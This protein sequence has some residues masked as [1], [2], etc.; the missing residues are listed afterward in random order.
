M[1]ASPWIIEPTAENFEAEVLVRSA[2][3]PVVVDFW[4]TWCAPC[5]QLA[6]ILEKLAQQYQ[7]QFI[8]AKVDTEKQP[9]LAAAFGVQSIPLV[10]AV[11]QG[12]IVDGFQGALG[13][14]Q[15]REFLDRILPSPM[16]K[17]LIEAAELEQTSPSEAEAKYREVLVL[18]PKLDEV[19]VALTRVLC[20]QQKYEEAGQVIAELEQRGY[21]EPEVESLK[22]QIEL[23]AAA[24]E[25]GSVEEARRAVAANPN[26][27]KAKILLIESLADVGKKTEALDLCLDIIEN[28]AGPV[29][30]QAKEVMLK[31]LA[32]MNDV[33]VTSQYRRQLGTL[34]L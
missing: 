1:A 34:W 28:G 19:K 31:V 13:E 24:A 21:L 11:K 6:P 18:E 23:H 32:T 17:L 30:D 5:R 29:R 2:S 4:A 27:F 9:D 26:D 7:G 15:V 33:L 25:S 22:A 20:A 14:A 8:L 10:V 16:E 12:Q 3:V